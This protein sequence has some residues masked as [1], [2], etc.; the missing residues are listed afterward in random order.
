MRDMM[1]I[2]NGVL[3]FALHVIYKIPYIHSRWHGLVILALILILTPV[4][5]YS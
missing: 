5:L 2:T 4:M 3:L 1:I